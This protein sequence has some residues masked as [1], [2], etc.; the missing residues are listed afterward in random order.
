MR[1]ALDPEQPELE[2]LRLQPGM[3]AEVMIVTGERTPLDYLLK[4]TVTSFGL[5]AAGEPCGRS[6][7][8]RMKV[9]VA[10]GAGYIGSH[11]CKAL[12]AGGFVPVVY[13]N[14]STGHRSFARWGPLVEGDLLDKETLVRV[15]AEHRP[16]AALHFAACAH[17][18]E[19]LEDP[20]KY[21]LNNVVGALHLVDA[22]RSAGNVPI[23]FSSTCAVYGEAPALPIAEDTPLAPVSPY[24]RTKLTVEHAL[25]DYGAAYGLRSVRLRYFNAGGCDPDGEV[26]E[27]HDPET[28]LIPRTILAAI[29]RLPELTIFGDDYPTPDGT[30]IRDYV[31]VCDL[32]D[33]HVAA[34]RLLLGGGESALFNLGTGTGLSVRQIID[35][36]GRV[37]H[38]PVP[39]RVAPSRPGNPAVLVADSSQAR[40]LLGFS[41]AHSDVET[42][43]RTAHAWLVGGHAVE[44]NR[45]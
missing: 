14:L 1:V 11:A 33:A 40:R 31:H 20:A 5:R 45:M 39:Y 8:A 17:V 41:T 37:T 2:G 15:F 13:D 34:V 32:A 4:P 26:G 30:A 7:T 6:D 42:V 43:V 28:H 25:A 19:S 12:A 27:S 38:L 9:L 24:G 3:P 35:A 36:V 23:V 22:A 16:A 21:Y 18:G 29:G 44:T 10:G